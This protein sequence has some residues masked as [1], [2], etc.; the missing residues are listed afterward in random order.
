MLR[1]HLTSLLLTVAAFGTETVSAVTFNKDVLPVLQKNCQ[2]CHRP[3]EIA[4]MSLLTYKEARPWAKA[5]KEAVLTKK[6]PPWFADPS[7]NHFSNDLNMAENDRKILAAWADGGAV[8]GSPRDAP[9]PV[10]FADGWEIGQPDIVVEM[11]QDVQIPATGIVR[12]QGVFVKVNFPKD[13]W[14]QSAE[15][16][17]G[18]RTVVHHMKAWIVYPTTDALAGAP[19]TDAPPAAGGRGGRGMGPEGGGREMLA[20]YNPGLDGQ[21]FTIGEAAKFIPAGSD[22]YF[23]THY[24]TNGTATTDRSKVGIVLAKNPPN[25]RFFTSGALTNTKFTIPAG[26]P[27]YEVRTEIPV[28]DNVE[29]T[30]IQPHMH[31]RGK[32]FE[33]TV[34]YPTGETQKVLKVNGYN[35]NWQ[36]GYEFA[37]PI[38]IPKGSKLLSIA[39]FDNSTNNPFNPDATKDVSFGG[40]TTDEMSVA[41]FSVVVDKKTDLTKLFGRA[42][43][44]NVYE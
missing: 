10:K 44:L 19:P 43:G 34:I 32:D 36:V 25:R 41:F 13:M 3:G 22:I 28:D 8:E 12:N 17:P 14:V 21:N 7:V 35:F 6:M 1:L 20:K 15:V 2:S 30:W 29:L 26:S 16:R 4:P 27:N 33:V 38:V 24:T 9:P 40:Q 18:N 5:I 37:K 23:E 11:P 42:S 39:H 31:M